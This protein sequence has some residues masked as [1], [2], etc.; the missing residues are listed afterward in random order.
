VDSDITSRLA[1]AGCAFGKFQKRLW[2]VHNI[3]RET[4]V[5]VYQAV[6]I[7]TLLYG[8][9]TWTLYQRSIRR[10]DQ[11]HLCCLCKIPGIKWQDRVTNTDVLYIYGTTGIEAFLL[12]AQL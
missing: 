1:K 11:F 10:L 5:A 9:E 4:K 8:C 2:G 12:K 3:S 6:V 7:T